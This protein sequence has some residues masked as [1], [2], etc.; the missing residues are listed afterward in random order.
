MFNLRLLLSG[1]LLF[2]PI[3]FAKTKVITS[4][5]ALYRVGDEITFL[6]DIRVGRKDLIKFR[7]FQSKVLLLPALGLDKASLKT[8]PSINKIR[9]FDKE[10]KNF[11]KKI[12]L[13]KK[14]LVHVEKQGRKFGKK[15]LKYFEKHK[16]LNSPFRTWSKT[17]QQLVTVEL[18]FQERFK[19]GS[20]HVPI[21]SYDPKTWENVKFYLLSLD[22]KI[23][24][25]VFF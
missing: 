2:S 19:K 12:I 13:M 4:D 10:S 7:C 6:S 22:K 15:Y 21:K 3:T 11:L 23:P 16:C 20:S 9:K 5:V 8:V 1:L 14:A 17:L 24:H 18:Y 25:N